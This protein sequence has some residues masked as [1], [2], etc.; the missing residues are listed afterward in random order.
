[1]EVSIGPSRIFE[2]LGVNDVVDRLEGEY[3]KK[4]KGLAG[5]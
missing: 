2:T 4:E 1:M 3:S 5:P